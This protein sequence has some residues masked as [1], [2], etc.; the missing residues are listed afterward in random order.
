MDTGCFCV[1]DCRCLYKHRHLFYLP[2]LNEMG[3][4]LESIKRI[5]DK[6]EGY[7]LLPYLCESKHFTLKELNNFG[8]GLCEICNFEE[9]NEKTNTMYDY[10]SVI[11]PLALYN[12]TGM[13]T[14]GLKNYKKGTDKK[15]P[16]LCS[17]CKHGCNRRHTSMKTGNNFGKSGCGICIFGRNGSNPPCLCSSSYVYK[18]RIDKKVLS[19]GKVIYKGEKILTLDDLKKIPQSSNTYLP[20]LCRGCPR[21]KKQHSTKMVCN[22]IVMGRNCGVCNNGGGNNN[23]PCECSSL[24]SSSLFSE[25]DVKKNIDKKIISSAE[26]SKNT[27][28][29]SVKKFWWLCKKRH[30]YIATLNSRSGKQ[31]TGCPTCRKSKMEKMM[32]GVLKNLQLNYKDQFDQKDLNNPILGRMKFDFGVKLANSKLLLVEMD[33]IQHF[34]ERLHFYRQ[35]GD[36][37]KAQ[38]RDSTKDKIVKEIDNVKLLRISYDY[39][40]TEK[41]YTTIITKSI[42]N[43]NKI[44]KIARC[45]EAYTFAEK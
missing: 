9:E 14:D 42:E 6:L 23:P 29:G 7:C 30:S 37:K 27:S 4:T 19:E 15:F 11:D 39:P 34:E 40:M 20:V 38:G 17:G 3:E 21:C 5:P 44:E 26:D 31:K 1:G 41:N 24:Y 10:I 45:G 32:E 43:Y 2:A 35:E 36:F 22:K 13:T 16:Y 28:L 33:G 25:L 8:N 18:D 12:R